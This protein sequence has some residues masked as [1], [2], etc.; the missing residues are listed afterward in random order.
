MDEQQERVYL[1][2]LLYNRE[3]T[4]AGVESIWADR[5]REARENGAKV[6][7]EQSKDHLEDI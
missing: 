7:L 1:L 4:I 5:I 2:T 3:I 6:A